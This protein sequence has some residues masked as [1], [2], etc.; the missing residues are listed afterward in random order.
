[1]FLALVLLLFTVVGC[2]AAVGADDEQRLVAAHDLVDIR[3]AGEQ[4]FQMEVEF[5]AQM[6]VSMTGHLTL[7][8]ASPEVWSTEIVMPPLHEVRVHR[9]GVEYVSSNA[10]STP[11]RIL[12]LQD[13]LRVMLPDSDR[14]KIN[15]VKHHGP[16]DGN[17]SCVRMRYRN[18]HVKARREV[19]FNSANE[20]VSDRQSGGDD[21]RQK[22]FSSYEP[23]RR[24][25]Y[26]RRLKLRVDSS[27]AVAAEV[28]S[29]R[30]ATFDDSSFAV[31]PGA[32]MRP[33][34]EQMRRAVAIKN[35]DPPSARSAVRGHMRGWLRAAV[36]VLPDGSLGEVRLFRGGDRAPDAVRQELLT[37]WKFKPAMCGN[38]AVVS[39]LQIED[40]F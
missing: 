23:F 13:L 40:E 8:W 16:A 36:T 1:M 18:A 28:V 22:E 24:R 25:R 20:V 6:M 31:P 39:D 21:F 15:G 30:E 7:K 3:A 29:L 33:Q 9:A 11:G 35:A 5:R 34:C 17:V 26:P 19:C 14:W 12:E 32:V 27:V 37:R 2:S 4:P 38:E 10:L